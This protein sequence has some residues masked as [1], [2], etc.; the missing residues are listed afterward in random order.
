MILSESPSELFLRK[1]LT[2]SNLRFASQISYPVRVTDLADVLADLAAA[3]ERY[4]A[5]K[6]AAEVAYEDVVA[7]A[8]DALRAGAEPGDV[9][10]RVPFTSTYM[11]TLARDAGIPGGRPG[12]KPSARPRRATQVPSP[13]PTAMR[14]T[15]PPK[16]QHGDTSS[17]T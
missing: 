9:Y 3:T 2:L 1:Q 11:R 16:G 8:L 12:I 7:K 5:S 4:E 17:P 14:T 13:G 15:K 10:E 6:R